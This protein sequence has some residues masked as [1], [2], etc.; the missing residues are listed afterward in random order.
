MTWVKAIRLRERSRPVI[1]T[2]ELGLVFTA[3]PAATKAIVIEGMDFTSQRLSWRQRDRDRGI[4]NRKYDAGTKVA[5]LLPH[6][7]VA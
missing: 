6:R 3:V 2:I 5:A 1:S 4:T 7:S